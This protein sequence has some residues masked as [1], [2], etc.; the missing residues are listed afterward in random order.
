MLYKNILLG[1]DGTKLM[2]KVYEHCAYLALLSNATVHIV[3]IIDNSVYAAMPIEGT[4]PG[5]TFA[6]TNASW[7]TVYDVLRETGKKITENAKKDLVSLGVSENEIKVTVLEGH[8]ARELLSYAE[9]HLIDLV[10]IGTHGR[11]GIDKL[12]IG[13]IADKIIR[14]SKVPVLVVRS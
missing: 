9:T 14:S 2:S 1:T 8:P 11:T 5:Y 10:I 6:P 4:L 3:N 7:A 13:G 12:L